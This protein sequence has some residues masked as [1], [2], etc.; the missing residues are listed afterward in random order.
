MLRDMQ[1]NSRALGLGAAVWAGISP[2]IFI[3][4]LLNT[5]T[6]LVPFGDVSTGGDETIGI[7][8]ATT[9]G[10]G[11]FRVMHRVLAGA[12]PAGRMPLLGRWYW[13]RYGSALACAFADVYTN[14]DEPLDDKLPR[15][16]GRV[17]GQISIWDP[18]AVI[19]L[20]LSLIHI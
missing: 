11:R 20:G 2:R 19:G 1:E 5:V 8:K 4:W 3:R 14:D 18:L 10:G 16:L 9:Q 12:E 7:A 17:I 15:A 13:K 6:A